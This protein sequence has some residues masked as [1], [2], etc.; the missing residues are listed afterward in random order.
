MSTTTTSTLSSTTA[1]TIPTST[2]IT[3][4]STTLIDTTVGADLGEGAASSSNIAMVGGIVG[5]IVSVIVIVGLSIIHKRLQ[6][7]LEQLHGDGHA[8]GMLVL[9]G[10]VGSVV[11]GGA[12]MMAQMARD[13]NDPNLPGAHRQPGWDS[14]QY[15]VH[16]YEEVDEMLGNLVLH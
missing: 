2:S 16:T 6:H 13:L 5:G 14:A 4:S 15:D 8:P 7:E 10:A 11:A 3:A 9:P 1:S 12:A